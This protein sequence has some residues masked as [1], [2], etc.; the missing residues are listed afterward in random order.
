MVKACGPS[1]RRTSTTVFRATMLYRLTARQT[2]LDSTPPLHGAPPQGGSDRQ[3]DGSAPMRSPMSASWFMTF[4]LNAPCCD[5]TQSSG[6]ETYR[7][8]TSAPRLSF[9]TSASA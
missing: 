9:D 4:F 6:M 8:S 5:G 1:P 3:L 2:E 7:T